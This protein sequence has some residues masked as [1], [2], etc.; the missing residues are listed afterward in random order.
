MISKKEASS[1]KEAQKET[2]RNFTYIIAPQTRTCLVSDLDKATFNAGMY[3]KSRF[4]A[5]ILFTE[6][7]RLQ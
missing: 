5:P 3:N 7:D 4:S 1:L 6:E 2:I